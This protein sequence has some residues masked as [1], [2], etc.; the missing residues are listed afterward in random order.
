MKRVL[1][2]DPLP[3]EGLAIL[4]Q[5]DGVDLDRR[6]GLK[7]DELGAAL[8][9]CDGVVLRSGTTLSAE[10]L[11]G[12]TR[13]KVIV[14]AGV[15]VDNIDV[16]AATREGIVVMNTPGGNTI[17]TAEQTMALLLALCRHTAAADH[18]LRAGR[19]DRKRFVG[20][21]L[22]GKT[23][24]IVG[25][26]RVGLAVAKRA[27][28]MEM[29][30]LGYDPF[31]SPT[32]AVELGIES[33][34]E[35]NDLYPRVDV[36]TVHVPLSEETRGLVGAKELAALREGTFVLNCA[37]GG[38]IDEAALHAALQDGHL[39][40][41]GIDVFETEPNT[42]SPLF[43]LPNVVVT[44][45]LGASTTEA[46]LSVAIEASQLM[47]DFLATGNVRFAVNMASID[48][49]E[50]EDLRRYLDIA[51]RLGSLQAQLAEGTIRSATIRFRGAVVDRNTRLI[52]AGFAVGLLQHALEE[53]VNLV[54]AQVLARERGIRIDEQIS[55]EPGDFT[56]SIR[57]EVE[58]DQ[59]ATIAAG[60]TRGNQYNRLVQ[61]GPYRIDT[62]LDGTMLIYTHVDKPGLIGLVG[63]VFGKH[64]VN[65]ATMTIGRDRPGGDAIGVLTLDNEPPAS[66][67]EEICADER[68]SSV[69]L[70]RLP[71][72]G[73]LPNCFG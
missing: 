11:K 34:A 28:G 17:S 44:P 1:I 40:G 9:E 36:L 31:L 47:V 60:T 5:A 12:R 13:L 56:S 69:R 43:A 21:Q 6:T 54:N 30:V 29:K 37:R 26:G 18:S 42:D 22:A 16:G 39:A 48:P 10:L 59:G 41:A 35:L 65:I 64:G 62:F 46:Q 67:L 15:G 8:A 73:T 38:I 52:T 24:G 71:P 53:N 2:A 25:L 63:T 61:M 66:A 27:L 58:T 33:V 55:S 72:A 3:A 51:H 68:I 7:G 19:W 49:S 50:L 57:T 45:H 14:R 4:E 32:R 20:T 70:V 23:L